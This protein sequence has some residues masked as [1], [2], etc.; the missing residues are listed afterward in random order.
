[1]QFFTHWLR[2]IK[3]LLHVDTAK[4]ILGVLCHIQ[5]GEE[6]PNICMTNPNVALEAPG[7]KPWTGVPW[8]ASVSRQQKQWYNTKLFCC[9]LLS[10]PLIL[11][12]VCHS[13]SVVIFQDSGTIWMNGCYNCMQFSLCGAKLPTAEVIMWLLLWCQTVYGEASAGGQLELLGIPEKLQ[14]SIE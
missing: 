4:H 3:V 13:N 10:Q 9:Q 8:P 11:D 12:R 2:D 1:M 5:P 6:T 14:N 7:V